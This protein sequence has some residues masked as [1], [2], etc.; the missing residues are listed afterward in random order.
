MKNRQYCKEIRRFGS[1]TWMCIR[2]PHENDSHYLVTEDRRK[3]THY[4]ENPTT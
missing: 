3:N 2:P 1:T 4:G